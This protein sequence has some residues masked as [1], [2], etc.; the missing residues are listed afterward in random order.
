[1]SEAINLNDI[2]GMLKSSAPYNH[3]FYRVEIRDAQSSKLLAA[4]EGEIVK[5][6]VN[7]VDAKNKG[8]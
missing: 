2:V 4:L 5:D 8:T 1:M 7:E 3:E 6:F